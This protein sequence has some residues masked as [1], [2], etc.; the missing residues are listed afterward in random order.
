MKDSVQK[1][2][3]KYDM[4]EWE[5]QNISAFPHRNVSAEGCKSTD[6]LKGRLPWD[7][8]VFSLSCI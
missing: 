5:V 8:K 6:W 1:E 4:E 3:Q 7:V 2:L